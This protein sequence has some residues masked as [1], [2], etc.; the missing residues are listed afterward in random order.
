VLALASCLSLVAMLR[1]L[2][3]IKPFCLM[4]KQMLLLPNLKEARIYLISS[5]G[6]RYLSSCV[7]LI[8]E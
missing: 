2:L 1:L 7:V 6:R 3:I 5:L 4:L 8:M